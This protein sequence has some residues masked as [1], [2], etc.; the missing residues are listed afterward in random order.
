MEHLKEYPLIS[1]LSKPNTD[2]WRFTTIFKDSV[3]S[4]KRLLWLVY[5]DTDKIYTVHGHENGKLETSMREVTPKGNNNFIEQ[6][7]QEARKKYIDKIREGYISKDI[8]NIPRSGAM[9]AQ[10]YIIGKTRIRYPVYC[11][12]KLDGI[13]MLV[14]REKDKL[15]CMSRNGKERNFFTDIKSELEVF[16]KYIDENWIIDGELYSDELEFNTLS[17]LCRKELEVDEREKYV[18]YYIFDINTNDEKPYEERYE[19]LKELFS[20]Y[21]KDL[22]DSSVDTSTWDNLYGSKCIRL[23]KCFQANSEE[24]IIDYYNQF[25]NMGH[26][27]VIIRKLA[28]SN[29]KKYLNESMYKASHRVNNILKY[30]GEM[31]TEEVTITGATTGVGRE[32]G[33]VIWKV[34]DDRDNDFT[35]RPT[36][37]MEE[38]KKLY[39]EFNNY[40]GKRYTIKFQGISKYGVPRFPVG[41][42]FRDYE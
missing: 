4:E 10:K 3:N 13:R 30:K 9:L 27:G 26:E 16:S 12:I 34:K 23:L 20:A 33:L 41:V 18:K 7:H 6:G 31:D 42:D 11:Q 25:K 29:E 28:N 40:I 8:T 5:F 19:I 39:S 15:Y 22:K 35:V 24:E 21:L 14:S 1:H 32:N 38:R 2:K 37:T 17:G 36:G